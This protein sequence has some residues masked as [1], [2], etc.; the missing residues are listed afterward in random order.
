ME[1]KTYEVVVNGEK[2]DSY[3]PVRQIIIKTDFG[4]YPLFPEDVQTI[5]VRE[6]TR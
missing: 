6:F 5:E 1:E 3:D 2:G 4:S